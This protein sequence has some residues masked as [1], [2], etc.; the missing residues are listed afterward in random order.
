MLPRSQQSVSIHL[1]RVEG[2]RQWAWICLPCG[3][4]TLKTLIG[5]EVKIY[6]I[7]TFF[8]WCLDIWGLFFF[9][10][11]LP[12]LQPSS[13]FTSLCQVFFKSKP[14][15]GFVGEDLSWSTSVD[16]G[17][18]LPP[19]FLMELIMICKRNILF[20]GII[21]QILPQTSRVV[22]SRLFATGIICKSLPFLN[23]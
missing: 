17:L 13:C 14:E 6:I 20:P 7:Q 10:V 9:R 4:W 21:F 16:L 5:S 19:K 23:F 8:C 3:L 22:S 1:R 12:K 11:F 2:A 15:A 18:S